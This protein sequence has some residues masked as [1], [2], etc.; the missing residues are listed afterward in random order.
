MKITKAWLEKR[1]ACPKGIEWFENQKE[2][3]AIKVVKALIK[4]SRLNWALW[5]LPQTMKYKQSVRLAIFSAERCLPMWEKFDKEDT[6]VKEA[7]EA[8]K[9][10]LKNPTK[11]NKEAA[12]SARSA[13][14]SATLTKILEFGIK[15]VE[16]NL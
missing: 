13:A 11:A 9:K 2:R 16:A 1:E 14:R 10:C 5:L 12:W 3:E 7:I 4:D 8:A 15:I 6:R